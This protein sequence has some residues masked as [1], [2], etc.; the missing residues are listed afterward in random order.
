[1]H[2][3]IH[4]F[5]GWL[6]LAIFE[7]WPLIVLLRICIFICEIIV[8]FHKDSYYNWFR[9]TPIK[10]KWKRLPDCLAPVCMS[11]LIFCQLEQSTCFQPPANSDGPAQLNRQEIQIQ[12]YVMQKDTKIQFAKV[13]N[14][15]FKNTDVSLTTFLGTLPKKWKFF[16]LSLDFFY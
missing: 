14:K 1:M 4:L 11:A 10:V 2:N 3:C 12:K 7:A 15:K 5:R 9:A 16:I 8:W 6:C 13:Q